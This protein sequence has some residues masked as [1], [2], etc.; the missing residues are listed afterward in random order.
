MEQ[1]MTDIDPIAYMQ[2]AR[3]NTGFNQVARHGFQIPDRPALRWLGETITWGEFAAQVDRLSEALSRR[4]LKSGDRLALLTDNQPEFLVALYAANRLGAI[5]VPLNFR[6]AAPEIAFILADCSPKLFVVAEPYSQVAIES[7]ALADNGP[8]GLIVIGEGSV[9]GAEKWTSVLAEPADGLPPVDVPEDSAAVIIY[10]SGTTGRPK[11]AVL[12]H[13]NLLGNTITM[14]RFYRMFTDDEVALLGVPLFHVGGIASVEGPV[15]LGGTVVFQDPGAF[16]PAGVLD[17]FEHERVTS[18]FLVPAQ[19]RQICDIADAGSRDCSAL[20]N[21]C[22]GG[23]PAT[24]QLLRDL[25][26]LFPLTNIIAGFGQTEMSPM[27]CVMDPESSIR[28]LGSVGRPIP[29]IAWRV[30]DDDM[31]DVPQGEIGEIVYRGPTTMLGYWNNPEATAEAFTGGWFHSGDLVRVDD[32]GYVWVVDR[33]KDMVISGGE[34]VYSAEVE[35]ALA[36]HPAIVDIAVIGRADERWGETPIAIAQLRAPLGIDELRAWAGAR[37]ARYKLPTA[38]VEVAQLP[39]NASGKVLKRDLREQYG[40][41]TAG[42]G[43][44]V[45]A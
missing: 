15:M 4:G 35:N 40:T 23:A 26:D 38:L 37:L 8:V 14:M 33:K 30:V 24:D 13:A 36:E 27:T 42:D 32:D 1:S 43:G 25:D 31:N 17:L 11:G 5:V 44:E 10:T 22:W 45:Q 12:S 6:L 19:L 18:T 9:P 16:D 7:T 2:A 21:I 3:R 29:T 28:K 41:S 34:N 20:R 39:R